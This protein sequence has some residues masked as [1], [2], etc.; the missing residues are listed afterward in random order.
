MYEFG[1]YIYE[2]NINV[3]PAPSPQPPITWHTVWDTKQTKARRAYMYITLQTIQTQSGFA[4]HGMGCFTV[5]EQW[6]LM[7]S[8]CMFVS[9]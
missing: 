4:G 2:P 1:S 5:D 8:F 6:I 9:L 7:V 3:P